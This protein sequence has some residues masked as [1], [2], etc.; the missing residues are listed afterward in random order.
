MATISEITKEIRLID[1]LEALKSC[2]YQGDCRA[3][4]QK[5]LLQHKSR[6]EKQNALLEKYEHMKRYENEHAGKIVAGI[7]EAGRG[8]IAG[9]VVA[10]AVILP[11][12]FTL[13]GLDDSKKLSMKKRLEFRGIIMERAD[14]GIGIATVEEIDKYNIYEATRLAMKRAVDGLSERPEHLLIDAM[15]LDTE[16]EQTSIIKGDANSNSI[17]AASVLAKTTRDMMMD[18]YSEEFPG[19]DFE[20]NKGYGTKKHLD[21]IESFGVTKIHRTTFE[22]VKSKINQKT[23]F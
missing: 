18:S 12:G 14:F 22:P 19:Y 16:I 1:S 2:S 21:G 9:E 17:A 20:N 6:L 7:D 23:L 15:T 3:G 10:A 4:V 5:A 13:P 11:Y 8:P